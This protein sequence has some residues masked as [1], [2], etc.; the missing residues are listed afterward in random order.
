[1]YVIIYLTYTCLQREKGDSAT[2]RARSRPLRGRS[3]SG[4]TGALPLGRGGKEGLF[5]GASIQPLFS[6][7]LFT[8]G[9]IQLLP[10]ELLPPSLHPM[11]YIGIKMFV[12]FSDPRRE[13]TG[14]R[15]ADFEG[16]FGACAILNDTKERDR[17]FPSPAAPRPAVFEPLSNP[18]PPGNHLL[19]G[20]VRSSKRRVYR[21]PRARRKMIDASLDERR[22]YSQGLVL[23][24]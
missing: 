2:N 5:G 24:K 23:C 8:A 13:C 12:A 3:L 7:V 17:A 19:R 16:V 22:K 14:I 11:V 10:S 1:M 18:L 9:L 15:H 6:S 4:G 21:N 20:N